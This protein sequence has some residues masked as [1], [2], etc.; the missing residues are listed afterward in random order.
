MA[1]GI[2]FISLAQIAVRVYL[3]D[4]KFGIPFRMGPDRTQRPRMFAGQCD[5]EPALPHM[6]LDER[7]DGFDGLLIYLAVQIQRTDGGDASPFAIGLA[8]KHFI[9]KL[10]LMR[11]FNDRR[12][13]LIRSGHVAGGVLV[14]G[15]K[16]VHT[17]VFRVTP[18]F[19]KSEE[20]ALRAFPS[21]GKRHGCALT[22]WGTGHPR[23][24]VPADLV[25]GGSA[26][27]DSLRG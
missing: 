16:H 2:A 25:S 14:R 10:H 21:G 9:V 26:W 13:T 4:A 6:R 20:V 19:F 23:S 27:V 7:L 5:D 17:R 3:D 1:V 22:G 24:L 11:R 12:R 8:V 15:G 18:G